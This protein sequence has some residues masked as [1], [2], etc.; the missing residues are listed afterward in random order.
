[1]K[2]KIFF[3]SKSNIFTIYVL[4][5][6]LFLVLSLY[7][8]RVWQRYKVNSVAVEQVDNVSTPVAESVSSESELLEANSMHPEFVI[9]EGDTLGS[10]LDEAGISATEAAEAI[11]T[12]SK[13][14]NPRK[15]NIGTLIE[16]SLEK[17]QFDN[18]ILKNMIVTIST[19]KKIEV[20][21]FGEKTFK[22]SEVLVPLIR[23][24]EKKVGFVKNSFTSSA[25][26]LSIPAS[27][28]MSMIRA[29]SYD[30]D[31][32]R[33]IKRGDKLEVII[34]KF[35]TEDG[36]LS[37]SGDVVYSSL[38]LSGG[39]KIS[40]YQFIDA[41]G[42]IAYYNEK[43]ENIKKEFLRTPINAA[44]I[45]S[46]FGMRQHPVSGYNK[47]HRGVDFAAPIGTPILAAG[48]G[49]VEVVNNY[50]GNYGKYIRIKHNSTY[51]TVYAHASRF[52]GGIKPGAKVSQGQVIAYVGV[53]GATTGPHLHYELI[54]SGK[55]I[56]PMKFKFASSSERLTGRALE[57][58]L[59]NKK[60]IDK[61]LKS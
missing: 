42:Q 22:V 4:V 53:T 1:M 49:V 21:R 15:L 40:L 39:K 32:Q 37:H 23:K 3:Q 38:T 45:S 54:E 50:Y 36:K 43:G 57:Q 26:E 11:K 58:F 14:Y 19:S 60:K 30:V 41:N 10:I 35:Y 34:D 6:S 5:T 29:F 16:L 56:N 51:S 55:Q 31:F 12:F 61:I 47:M 27:A 18:N 44:R 17:D 59:E 28:I 9:N 8:Y 48:G 2:N 46:K 13:K 7:G 52:A 25:L 24:I 33:D 20:S